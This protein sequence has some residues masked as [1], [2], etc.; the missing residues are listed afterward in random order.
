MTG[1][2]LLEVGQF[3]HCHSSFSLVYS[4]PLNR[5]RVVVDSENHLVAFL[6]RCDLVSGFDVG[7]VYAAVLVKVEP[8]C[9]LDCPS[10]LHCSFLCVV[11]IIEA[12]RRTARIACARSLAGLS[13]P[14]AGR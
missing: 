13:S 5:G 14:A 8:F 6:L 12:K 10:G 3:L 9:W 4:H 2:S 7:A 11:L 1:R